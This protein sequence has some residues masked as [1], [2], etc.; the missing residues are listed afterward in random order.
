[1]M[2]L[3]NV[4]VVVQKSNFRSCKIAHAA[5]MNCTC[6]ANSTFQRF[7]EHNEYFAKCGNRKMK[8]LNPVR[9]VTLETETPQK[10]FTVVLSLIGNMTVARVA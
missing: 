8:C 7:A 5:L 3:K 1:V 4:A 10:F 2:I 9:E 6:A